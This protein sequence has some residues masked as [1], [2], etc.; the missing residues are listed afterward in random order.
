MQPTIIENKVFK[1]LGCVFYGDPFHSAKEWTYEN[2]ISK[3]WV[4]FGRVLEKNYN[5]LN[6]IFIDSK[7]GYELHIEPKEFKETKKYYV[8]VAMEIGNVQEIPLE[9]YIK[10][11]PKANYI[12]YTTTVGNKFNEGSYIYNK[13][14]PENGYQQAF[15]YIIQGYVEQRY[16]PKTG[17][18]NPNNEI[19]WYIPIK[20]IELI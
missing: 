20:K 7:V 1:L 5:L 2:E 8:M 4:R 14:I 10:I 15:P 12:L 17:L 3:L 13:W 6:K 9:M 18:N 11:L 19:D 16:D